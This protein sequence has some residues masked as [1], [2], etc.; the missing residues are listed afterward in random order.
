MNRVG[1]LIVLCFVICSALLAS[2][3]PQSQV[4]LQGS[5]AAPMQIGAMAFSGSRLYMAN[6]NR[7]EIVY[8]DL[9]TKKMTATGIKISAKSQIVDMYLA[10]ANLYL[11]DA[12]A[13]A[14][15]IYDNLGKLSSTIQTKGAKELKFSKAKRLLV[16]YQGFIY[17][18]DSKKLYALSQEGMLMATT[19]LE[20]PVSMSLGED[21][22]IRVLQHT[23]TGGEVLV[24]DLN[25]VLKFRYKT[26]NPTKKPNY[27]IDLAVNHW[28]EMHVLNSA[29]VGV[30]KLSSAAKTIPETRFGALNKSGALGSFQSP[31][32]IKCGP[33][34]DGSIM[35]IY[36]SKQMAIHLFKDNEP[37]VNQPLQRPTYT[38]RPSLEESKY[39][40]AKDFL[41][42]EDRIFTIVSMPVPNKKSKP[43]PVVLCTDRA[44]K[45]NFAI[46]LQM[47]KDKKKF[48]DFTALAVKK[49]KLYVLDKVSCYVH[50]FDAQT[51]EYSKSFAGKGSQDGSLMSPTSL[52]AGS[53]GNLYVADTGNRRITVFNE[54]DTFARNIQLLRPS[55]R[56]ILLRCSAD[57]LY[58]LSEDSVIM[59]TPLKDGKRMGQLTAAKGIVSFD[60]IAKGRIGYVDKDTQ[61]LKIYNGNV[62]EYEY[63]TKSNSAAFPHFANIYLLR[64][65]KVQQ[66]L[67][68]MDSKARSA[69]FLYFYPALDDAKSIRLALSEGLKTVLSWEA[70]PGIDNWIV[71]VTNGDQPIAYSVSQ[72]RYEV[73]ETQESLISYKVRLVAA[74][75]KKGL[76]SDSVEDHFSHAQHLYSKGLYQRAVEAFRRSQT[77]IRDARIDGEIVKCYVAESDR[78]VSRQEYELALG[79]LR[80]ASSI[81]STSTEIALKAVNI[82]KRMA[83]YLGGIS[84]LNGNNYAADKD[85]LKEYI[86]L[87]YLS[88]DYDTVVF[89]AD[90]Y[91]LNFK[92]WD[93]E[94]S[95]YWAASYEERGDYQQALSKYQEIA[96]KVQSFND[97]LKIGELQIKLKQFRAAELHLESMRTKYRQQK[98]DKVRNLLGNCNMQS[99][100]YGLAIDH[101]LEAVRIDAAVAEYHNNLGTAYLKDSKVTDAQASLK[102]AHDLAPTNAQYGMDYAAV[103]K[104]QNLN[105]DAL[106]VMDAVADQVSSNETAADFHLLYA[107]LLR[108]ELRLPE[109]YEQIRRAQSYRPDDF[110]INQLSSDI[111]IE[112]D[113]TEYGKEPIEM[114]RARFKPI[115][116]SLDQHYKNNP[117]GSITLYNNKSKT[118]TDAKLTVF[119]HEVGSREEEISIPAMIPKE[120]TVI[121]IKMG[122][123]DRLF[124]R[125]RTVKVDIKLN[126]TYEGQPFQKANPQ[127]DLEILSSKALDW[128]NRRSLASF[129]N[130]RDENLNYFVRNNIGAAFKNV[131][132]NILNPSLIKALQAYSFYRANGV[133][134]SSDSSVSNLDASATDEVP[135][136]QQLL[137]TKSGDC[138][139]LLVLMAATLETMSVVTGFFDVPSHVMLAIKTDMSEAQ[140]LQNGLEPEYFIEFKG[141]Q[142]FPLETTMMGKEDFVTSWLMAISKY[143]EVVNSGRVPDIIEFADAHKL[144]PPSSYSKPI[145]AAKFNKVSEAISLYQQ[146]LIQLQNM[147]QLNREMSFMDALEKYPENNSV[148]LQYARYSVENNNIE[149][150]ERLYKEVLNRD[151]GNFT[152]LMNLGIIYAKSS[153]LQLAR[154][155][156]L[157]ALEHASGKEDKVYAN[158]CLMEYRNMNRAKAVE[159]FNKMSRKD[160]I[161]EMD[162]QIYADLMKTGE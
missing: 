31:A 100:S 136:P 98:L 107:T 110:E 26:P 40:L 102:R 33:Y 50:V 149:Q 112:L 78:Y 156:Y 3:E 146:D 113:Q 60:L 127:Q 161:R 41:A 106:A 12:K 157:L 103:L 65:D 83:D 148:R 55:Q 1:L 23:K 10:E 90:R 99:E 115:Y 101:Y 155:Q 17:V 160:M 64:F 21:Q 123:N 132:S 152:A 54:Y 66:R 36:D 130:P 28:G 117:I 128:K 13:N 68:I 5:K 93:E 57:D 7:K 96:T 46:Y 67:A 119:V 80:N 32:M 109:A 153:R 14:I 125:P 122:F 51:G 49:D 53:D 70:S 84:Y 85:L 131:S 6:L 37:S 121:D 56:P 118:I 86:T 94:V 61:K 52:V 22:M 104:R 89:E 143:K 9:D 43:G 91:A 77:N 144:Y 45:P 92:L 150:A 74:D 162:M 97:E 62:R 147:S 73:P 138:E 16:N 11:L 154:E 27:I 2:P 29:P 141:A 71:Q 129:V 72:P 95:R 38:E 20:N 63:F 145:A 34:E 151:P 42:V 111:K 120:D 18:M 133:F 39:P 8:Y 25:L 137:E 135:F 76:W 75:G 105:R 19:L 44:G 142:W 48:R 81:R 126:Y 139:D 116:P 69:R 88:K 87:K 124:D 82:Y 140:I 47:Q 58:C 114:Q 79:E 108:L 4:P 15:L 158:L 159:Y 30:E 35:A 134:Y 59:K 24:Y